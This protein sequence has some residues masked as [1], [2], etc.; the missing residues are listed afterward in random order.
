MLLA[1]SAASP[2]QAACTQAQLA[3]TWTAEAL[4]LG[5]GGHLIWITCTLVINTAGGVELKTS[6]CLNDDGQR[7]DARGSLKIFSGLNCAYSGGINLVGYK[8]DLSVRNL[9]LSTDHNV[10]SGI[11]GGGNFGSAFSINM[12]KVK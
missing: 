1:A 12:I 2:A 8:S 3:G 10:A 5:T 6:A 7:S 9:T 4:S 11:G